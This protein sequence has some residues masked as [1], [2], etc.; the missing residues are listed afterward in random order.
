MNNTREIIRD[1]KYFIYSDYLR[2]DKQ[3]M[4]EFI[5]SIADKL[6]N[7]ITSFKKNKGIKYKEERVQSLEISE[8]HKKHALENIM[9]FYNIEEIISGDI[10]ENMLQDKEISHIIRYYNYLVEKFCF[11]LNF[12]QLHGEDISYINDD[13]FIILEKK[14]NY[15]LF[16]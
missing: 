4:I 10:G 12:R 11:L 13:K 7:S 6:D 1:F 15:F 16:I 5:E 14:S 8:F 3:E 2:N 9:K